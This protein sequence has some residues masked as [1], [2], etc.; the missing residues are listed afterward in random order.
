[1]N[2]FL[3]NQ[4]SNKQRCRRYEGLDQWKRRAPFIHRLWTRSCQ[5]TS[6]TEKARSCWTW[7]GCTRRKGI[8]YILFQV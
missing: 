7:L 3:L 1:M 4:L 5:C 8:Y 6:S 2:N